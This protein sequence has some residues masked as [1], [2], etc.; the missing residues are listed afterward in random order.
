MLVG[1]KSSGLTDTLVAFFKF[2]LYCRE[3]SA[4]GIRPPV[5]LCCYNEVE[6]QGQSL[7][8]SQ[9]SFFAAMTRSFTG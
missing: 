1:T 5:C 4:H 8:Q 2:L 7:I 9:I 6:E 3:E